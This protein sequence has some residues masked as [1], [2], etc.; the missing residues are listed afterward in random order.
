MGKQRGLESRKIFIH[1][2]TYTGARAMAAVLQSLDLDGRVIG[3]SDEKTLDL[4]AMHASGEECYP[5]KITVGDILKLFFVQ[6]HRADET[7]ILFPTSNGPCRFGQYAPLME[8]ILSENGLGDVLVLS[9]TCEDGYSSFEKYVGK[10][11]KPAWLGIVAADLL[12]KVLLMHRP[13]EV[14]E[15]EADDL[16]E[17][18]LNDICQTIRSNGKQPD[19]CLKYL[20]ETFVKIRDDFSRL[21]VKREKRPLI[22]IVGEIFCRLNR[23]S[24]MDVIRKIEELGGE[25]WQS[26]VAE[27]ILYSDR[28]NERLLKRL[29]KVFS[30]DMVE[31]KLKY[32]YQK[33]AE[34]ALYSVFKET[35]VGREEPG[36]VLDVIGLA[37]PYLSQSG[38][39]GEMI[40]S[41]GK[42][43]YYC[44]KGASG[45]IDI[46]PFSCM[47]GIVSESIYYKLSG[48]L[49]GLPIKIFYFD[50]THR[51]LEYDLEIFM[52]IARDFGNRERAAPM[53]RVS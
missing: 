10:I 26:D 28:E 15:G 37:S 53:S 43:V 18:S 8:K 31:A 14:N 35:F 16:F 29:G 51:D 46:S 34:H 41:V 50:E 7:A 23:Y 45:V 9:P 36:D 42:A 6:G 38:A 24:N 49:G 33:K 39:L 1:P 5:L 12:R 13:Y 44:N 40:L 20:K 47:N 27:W 32:F 19:K 22:G 25:A 3:P 21:P 4:G 2:M 11:K 30:K 48:D 17:R 52:D